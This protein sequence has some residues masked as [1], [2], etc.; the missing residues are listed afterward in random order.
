M[1]DATYKIMIARSKRDKS[2]T[3]YQ[4]MTTTVDGVTSPLELKGKTAL[5]EKVEKMLNE[6]GFAKSDFIIVEVIDYTIDA[7]SYSDEEI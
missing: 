3:L 5:D 6:E 7:D 4:F 1:D 2:E